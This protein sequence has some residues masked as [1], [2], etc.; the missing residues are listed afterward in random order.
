[1]TKNRIWIAGAAIVILAIVGLGWMLGISPKLAE[2]DAAAA[3]RENVESQ[4]AVLEAANAVLREQFENLDELE[5]ELEELQAELP[6]KP[7]VEAFIAYINEEALKA[8]V[9]ITNIAMVEPSTY[10]TTEDGESAAPAEDA[11]EAPPAEGESEA[12][13]PE[14]QAEAASSLSTW[15]FSVGLGVTV[16]GF[17]E[18]VMAFSKGL[19]N[20]ERLFLNSGV[21][22]TSGAV[23]ELGGTVTG[24][25]FVLKPPVVEGTEETTEDE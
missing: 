1:M 7:E 20:S 16:Q 21:V 2:A 11:S 5:A 13:A 22:F 8:G 10:G 15:L 25:L 19:Q 24:S 14:G 23:G 9:T 17:P 6:D 12:P 18:Q 3:V 4:N